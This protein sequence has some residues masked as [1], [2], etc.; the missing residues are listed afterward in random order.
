MSNDACLCIDIWTY[1]FLSQEKDCVDPTRQNK[2]NTVD[3]SICGHGTTLCE[4]STP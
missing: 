2:Q 1:M 4:F 3:K